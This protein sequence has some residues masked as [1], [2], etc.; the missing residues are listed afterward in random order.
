MKKSTFV[1]LTIAGIAVIAIFVGFFS[2]YN[3]GVTKVQIEKDVRIN[4]GIDE[5]WLV[6]IYSTDTTQAMLFYSPDLKGAS[7]YSV[8]ENYPGLNFRY[9]FSSGGGGP[10]LEHGLFRNPFVADSGRHY[11]PLNAEWD[12]KVEYEDGKHTIELDSE[13]PYVFIVPSEAENL[14]IYD[15]NGIIVDNQYEDQQ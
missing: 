10:M 14:T 3:V 15:V 12:C 7:A 2:Y 8:Y 5:D 13:K 6:A 1:L 9:H 11:F 4:H